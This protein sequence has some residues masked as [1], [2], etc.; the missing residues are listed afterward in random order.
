MLRDR[1]TRP[2]KVILSFGGNSNYLA[3]CVGPNTVESH[4]AQIRE[5]KRIW[6]GWGAGVTIVSVPYIPFEPSEDAQI[7]MRSEAY[8]QGMKAADG[9]IYV[10]PG[11]K[12]YWTRPCMAGERCVGHQINKA[13]AP[14]RNIVRSNDRVHFCPGPPHNLEPCGTYSS[15]SWRYARALTAAVNL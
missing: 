5:V 2:D 1:T 11:R 14:G 13:V 10:T 12:W 8:R 3:P 15:G 9:G 6:T 7:A 4:R